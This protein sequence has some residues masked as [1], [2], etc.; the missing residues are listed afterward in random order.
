MDNKI[1]NV[2]PLRYPGGKS[3]ACKHLDTI[4]NKYFNIKNINTVISPF[5]GGGSFEFYLQNKYDMSIMANDKFKPLA[6]FWKCCKEKKEKLCNNLNRIDHV[7]NEIFD[8]FRKSIMTET[9]MLKQSIYYFVINRCSF[10][11]STLSGGFSQE[12]S[13]KRFTKSSIKRL[14]N[15][16][17]DKFEISNHDFERYVNNCK[18]IGNDNTIMFLDPPYYLGKKSKLYGN[19]GDLHEIFDHERLHNLLITKKNWIMTYNDCEYI[20]NLYSNYTIIELSWKYRMNKTKKSSEIAI[21]CN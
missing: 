18:M 17:L 4:L 15:L 14:E 20:R 21:I 2:S 6:I 9:N 8:T 10:S 5:F 19:C 13:E 11:G 3:R 7:T 12:S 16:N 1:K